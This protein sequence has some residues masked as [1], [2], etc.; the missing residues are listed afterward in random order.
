MGRKA[1]WKCILD[2]AKE[3]ATLAV[4]LYNDPREPRGLEAF[5]VHMHLAWQHLCHARFERELVPYH[6]KQPNGRYERVDGERKAWE[7]GECLVH[8]RSQT[9]PV[10]AN[11]ELTIKLRNKVEHRYTSRDEVLR[12]ATAGYCQA[13]VLNFER[14][15]V[16]VFGESQSLAANLR[17]P[18]FLATFLE[19]AVEQAR[20]VE[21]DLPKPVRGL[22]VDYTRDLEDDVVTDPRFEFR[23]N[24]IPKT[25]PKSASD[26]AMQF[27]R[28][29][30]LSDEQRQA[31]EQLSMVIVRDQIRPVSN[32]GMLKPSQVARKVEAA[33]P[34]RFGTNNVAE[35][36][37]KLRV[38]PA[39]NDPHPE[40]T[41][42]KYCCYDEPHGDYVYT[43]AFVNK[44]IREAK[45]ADRYRAFFGRDPRPKTASVSAA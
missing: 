16:D 27:V 45:T 34:F 2:T 38:R 1:K 28:L 42:D 21:R 5:L 32:H 17:V 44:L 14:E 40:R 33:I 4:A 18:I 22:L 10:R 6:Y 39:A 15:L 7:L 37:K 43:E 12:V 9:D 30:E 35:A 23:V 24:L 20:R 25:G 8:L 11:L 36:W 3:E 31:V 41:I 13:L 29:D 26:V 19:P